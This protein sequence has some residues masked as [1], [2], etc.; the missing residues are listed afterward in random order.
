MVLLS[1]ATPISPMTILLLP[2]VR[3][4]AAYPERDVVVAGLVIKKRSTADGRVA[5]TREVNRQRQGTNRYVGVASGVVKKRP[6]ADGRVF[7][8]DGVAKKRI[9]TDGCV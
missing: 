5:A 7:G 1:P 2:V 3:S 8:A 4:P 9:V 6:A